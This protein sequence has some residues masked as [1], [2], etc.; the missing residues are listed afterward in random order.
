MMITSSRSKSVTVHSGLRGVVGNV[1]CCGVCEQHVTLT[2]PWTVPPW[3]YC[4]T[5]C[6]SGP[7]ESSVTVKSRH[8]TVKGWKS[9]HCEG[10]SCQTLVAIRDAVIAGPS[11][12]RQPKTRWD[13]AST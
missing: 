11:R 6:R 3:Q 2:R 5:R 12:L 9:L 10:K 7:R 13:A 8:H 4:R 1:L